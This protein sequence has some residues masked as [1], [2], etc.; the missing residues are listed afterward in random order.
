MKKHEIN[1]II[2]AYVAN[3][4][5][6]I[7]EHEIIAAYLNQ[8]EGKPISGNIFR[9][10]P[11]NIRFVPQYGMYYLKFTDSGREHLIGYN[12][13]PVVKS[14]GEPSKNGSGFEYFDNCYGNAARERLQW[15]ADIQADPARF[16]E[17]CRLFLKAARLW[18]ELRQ[19]MADIEASGF[20]SY[21]NPVY[22]SILGSFL[23]DKVRS[24]L[25]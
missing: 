11:E 25:Y 10:L 16:G 5:A 24:E 18:G 14:G 1:K 15:L 3:E 20:D 8:Y 19:T 9:K 6:G 2:A 4:S 21:K 23:P 13:D 12:S 7:K 17:F 22:Y